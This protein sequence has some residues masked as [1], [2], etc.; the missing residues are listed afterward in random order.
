MVGNE[1]SSHNNSYVTFEHSQGVRSSFPD[2]REGAVAGG[3]GGAAVAATAGTVAAAVD[4]DAA[5][6]HP[7]RAGSPIKNTGWGGAHIF[8]LSD[9]LPLQGVRQTVTPLSDKC[10]LLSDSLHLQDKTCCE[11]GAMSHNSGGSLAAV[12]R[13]FGGSLAAVWRTSESFVTCSV[14]IHC[15]SVSCFR[16]QLARSSRAARAQLARIS[17]ASILYI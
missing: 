17:R 9:K 2:F 12:W 11:T 10:L 14:L 3:D 7:P 6:S 8:R 13:Q 15:N 5:A 16:A 4:G 1:S